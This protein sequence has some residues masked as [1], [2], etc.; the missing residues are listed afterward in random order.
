MNSNRSI[1]SIAGSPSAPS[2][3]A[4]LLSYLH[5]LIQGQT[6]AADIKLI[7]VRDLNHS[8]LITAD[9]NDPTLRMATEQIAAADGVIMATPVYKAAY[10]GVLK[11]LLDVLPQNALAGKVILPIVSGGAPAHMLALDY[12]LKPVLAALGGG[13]ILSGVYLIDSQYEYSEGRIVR[14]TDASAE[15]KLGE[16]ALAFIKAIEQ[17]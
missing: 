13:H 16:A 6:S 9:F 4:A 1:V 11:V 7:T 5:A 12:A 3:S 17:R 14:F 15:N 2:R 8:A 10:S